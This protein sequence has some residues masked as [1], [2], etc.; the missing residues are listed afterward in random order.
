MAR[1]LRSRAFS[2]RRSSSI[3]A[4]RSAAVPFVFDPLEPMAVLVLGVL[5][6]RAV[7]TLDGW[8]GTSRLPAPA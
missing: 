7:R 1:N 4:R 8:S 6:V 3:F 2:A 5:T